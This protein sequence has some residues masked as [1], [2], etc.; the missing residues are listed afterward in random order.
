MVPVLGVGFL[1][2]ERNALALLVNPQDYELSGFVLV[3]NAGRLDDKPLDA[4]RQELSVQDFEHVSQCS[5]Y[6]PF[7]VKESPMAVTHVTSQRGQ[8][9][10]AVCESSLSRRPGGRVADAPSPRRGRRCPRDCRQIAGAT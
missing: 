6:K 1:D 10:R 8:I 4:G 5:P 2:G 3:G 9:T 7:S